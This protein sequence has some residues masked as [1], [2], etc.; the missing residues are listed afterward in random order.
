MTDVTSTL[1]D[2]TVWPP[3]VL[4]NRSAEVV[5]SFETLGENLV[6]QE[7]FTETTIPQPDLFF[8]GRQVP[9]HDYRLCSLYVYL[10]S[11]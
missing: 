9:V 6:V 3:E 2:I 5:M 10:F 8:Q 4:R 7:N 1:S 11:V